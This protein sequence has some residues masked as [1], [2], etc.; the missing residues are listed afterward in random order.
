MGNVPFDT[1]CILLVTLSIICSLV[2]I[3]II[4]WVRHKR[5][6][7]R[8][9]PSFSLALWISLADLPLRVID[10]LTNQ[11]TL[12]YH[13]PT[14][15]S[16]A[17]FLLWGSSFTTMWFVYLNV[18]IALDLH[19]VV[20]HNLP[21][22]ARIRSMYPYLAL[23]FATFISAWYLVL[24]RVRFLAN[25]S[26]AVDSNGSAAAAFSIL[27]NMVWLDLA[28]VYVTAVMVAIFVVL[29]RNRKKAK[30][31]PSK[32]AALDNTAVDSLNT[33]A[34]GSTTTNL[35]EAKARAHLQNSALVNNA[36]LIAA[37]P[38]ILFI[39]Y[40]PNTLMTLLAYLSILTYSSFFNKIQVILFALQ[41]VFNLGT[42][43]I[44]PAML[45]AYQ[46][47]LFSLPE[48]FLNRT[49]GWS[50]SYESEKSRAGF[51]HLSPPL[52][53]KKSPLSAA[54]GNGGVPSASL[55]PP[56]LL[57]GQ[58]SPAILAQYWTAIASAKLQWSV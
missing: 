10:Y 54:A 30:P 14:Q 24:P 37:Y 5:P 50:F 2:S 39:V 3:G 53:K 49:D 47:G 18:M 16:F 7:S 11:L 19:L 38:I 33:Q 46:Q 35:E 43:L 51:Q 20:F 26:I 23:G 9:S 6:A 42:L 29:F 15:A 13:P 25:A 57:P 32:S 41:G 31:S 27:W 44:H 36:R 40:M 48:F 34:A 21:R 22:Q 56:P 1:V 4:L 52:G 12:G 28:I 17:R 58:T 8:A 45:L 55:L